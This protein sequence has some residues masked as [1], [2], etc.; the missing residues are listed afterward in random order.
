MPSPVHVHLCSLS[1]YVLLTS[2]AWNI[3]RHFGILTENDTSWGVRAASFPLH[4]LKLY[5]H[6]TSPRAPSLSPPGAPWVRNG[7]AGTDTGAHGELAAMPCSPQLGGPYPQAWLTPSP[8]SLGPC[9]PLPVS[10]GS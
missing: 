5:C 6:V 10:T 3:R 4:T 9:H 8:Q 1:C 2:L 7:G